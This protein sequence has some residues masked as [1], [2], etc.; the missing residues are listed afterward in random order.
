MTTQA[1][2]MKKTDENNWILNLD[3]IF[4]IV[5]FFIF[6]F[7]GSI[8]K[9]TFLNLFSL[10]TFNNIIKFKDL[11]KKENISKYLSDTVNFF[12]GLIISLILIGIN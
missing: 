3:S 7:I 11:W 2:E 6:T 5:P 12:L 10:I 9:F 4:L 8:I 1:F